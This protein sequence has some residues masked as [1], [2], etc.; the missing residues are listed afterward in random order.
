M[1]LM[2]CII[3]LNKILK[4]NKKSNLL[5]WYIFQSGS[6]K[7]WMFYKL[8]TNI[9]GWITFGYQTMNNDKEMSNHS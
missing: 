4:I 2:L 7:I 1:D 8:D 6:K 3:R 5:I 9:L